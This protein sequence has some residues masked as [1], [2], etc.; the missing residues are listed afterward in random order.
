MSQKR[1]LS[2]QEFKGTLNAVGPNG[3]W[4]RLQIPFDVYACYGTRGRVSVTGTIN[5]FEFQS[6]LFPDGEGGFHMMVNKQM[7]R[8]AGVKPGDVVDVVMRLDAGQRS[9]AVP[10]DVEA[11]MKLD[12]EAQAGFHKMTPS[13]RKEYVDWITSAKQQ[14]TRERRIAKALPM[15][16][17]GKRL[18]T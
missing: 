1:A 4:T 6:S 17:Q 14:E 5:G 9:V 7:Q 8:E 2:Q 13:A 15:I 16:A 18:R 12:K 11:A 3:A 10:A